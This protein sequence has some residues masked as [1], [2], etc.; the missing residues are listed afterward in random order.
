MRYYG[1]FDIDGVIIDLL[2]AARS[3]NSAEK[4]EGVD[5]DYYDATANS[6]ISSYLGT[7]PMMHRFF[8]E[9]IMDNVDPILRGDIVPV[10]FV[11]ARGT[12]HLPYLIRHPNAIVR[13]VLNMAPIF[14]TNGGHKANI[15]DGIDKAL[16]DSFQQ[17]LCYFDDNLNNCLQVISM[18]FG[19]KSGDVH[20]VNT[21]APGVTL[22]E[23]DNYDV[24][25]FESVQSYLDDQMEVQS[26]G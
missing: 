26:D 6:Y 25:S 15:V 3:L 8:E 1:I 13:K 22:E 12:E 19:A 23:H 7:N 24:W 16:P 11:T 4:Y 2:G 10:A 18:S 20:V 5:I 14:C 17:Q 21:K 9:P